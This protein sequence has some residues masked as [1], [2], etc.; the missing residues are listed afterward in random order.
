MRNVDINPLEDIFRANIFKMLKKEEKVDD[1]LIRKIS[2]WKHSGFSVH[3][4]VHIEKD[5]KK[6][7]EALSQWR[8]CI[9][10][11]RLKNI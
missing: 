9:A 1:D 2:G 5:N 3:N 7:R 4:G 10:L 11:K 6:G 8:D